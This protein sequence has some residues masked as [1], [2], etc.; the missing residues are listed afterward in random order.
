VRQATDAV[1]VPA[2]AIVNADGRD[3]VWTVR[4]GRYERVPVT[5]GV[6]GEDVVQV[7][8]GVEPGQRIAVAGVDRIRPG[9]KT[10]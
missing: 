1:T 8:S 4:D 10:S 6:Q 9:A 3:T 5:V 2:S 7:T